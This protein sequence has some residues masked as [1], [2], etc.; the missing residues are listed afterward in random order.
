MTTCFVTSSGTGIG[1]THVCRRLL[2]ALPPDLTRRCIKPVIS[3]FDPADAEDSDT[4]LLLAAQGLAV[5]ESAIAATSPWRY[6]APLSPDMAAAREERAIPFGELVE[7]SRAPDG[8]ELNLIEGVGGVMAPLDERHTVLDWIAALDACAVLVVGSYLGTLS[9]T[10]TAL[11]VLRQ[12]AVEVLAIVISQS[13]EEPVPAAGTQTNLARRV[14]D[15]PVLLLPRDA[16]GD[17]A[18]LAALVTK[19]CRRLPD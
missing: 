7:F 12:R 4:A 8:I 13:T 11:A 18:A 3:G 15:V 14:P 16:A 17:A 6:R 9:H 2:A 19:K 1:K 10:L 5:D